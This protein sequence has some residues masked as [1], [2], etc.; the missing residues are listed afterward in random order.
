MAYPS[1]LLDLLESC[2]EEQDDRPADANVLAEKLG[3]LT[4]L[5]ADK[6]EPTI[7]PEPAKDADIPA[8]KHSPLIIPKSG[9]ATPVVTAEPP[10]DI[11]NSI[12]MKLTLIPAGEFQMG[13][14]DLGHTN[15]EPRHLSES[16]GRFTW[17]CTRFRSANTCR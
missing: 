4:K 10:R 13:A 3:Q 12:G 15:A 9:E 6:R 14:T 7:I 1:K 11:V 2:F 17:G 5:K 8:E 16:V